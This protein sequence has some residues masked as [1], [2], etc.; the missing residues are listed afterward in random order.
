[1]TIRVIIADDH[2]LVR[3]GLRRLLDNERDIRVVDE[4]ADGQGAIDAVARVRPDVIVMDV[5]M[6]VVNG[7]E[8]AC[9]LRDAHPETRV[10][11]LSMYTD[12]VLIEKAL[13]NGVSG[14]V[15]KDSPAEELVLAIR[16]AYGGG[17]HKSNKQFKAEST[18]SQSLVVSK[19]RLTTRERQIL[20]LIASGRTNRQVSEKLSV[21]VKTIGHHRNNLMK[22]LNSHSLGDMIR[23]AIKLGLIDQGK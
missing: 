23:T 20:Q 13:S 9:R 21:S 22:K 8:A 2:H 16:T 7:I 5:K 12:P 10:V 18:L 4:A 1:M 3:Q 19:S 6:P 14:F 11:V 17:I 15:C